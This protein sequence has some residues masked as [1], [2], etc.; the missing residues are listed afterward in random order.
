MSSD[1][2]KL[3]VKDAGSSSNPSAPASSFSMFP[4][5]PKKEVDGNKRARV[6]VEKKSS[7]PP[8][9]AQTEKLMRNAF[10]PAGSSS[11]RQRSPSPVMGGAKRGPK[12]AEEK[13]R[14][15]GEFVHK[16][17]QFCAYWE[18]PLLSE[19]L[20]EGGCIRPPDSAL[21]SV[22]ALDG[23]LENIRTVLSRHGAPKK[24]R[25]VVFSMMDN[26]HLL[27]NPLSK[28]LKKPVDLTGLGQAA[29]ECYG[30]S[31]RNPELEGLDIEAEIEE[32]AIEFDWLFSSRWW[33]RLALKTVTL[34]GAVAMN[35]DAM[36]SMG[37]D[38]SGADDF[39][40]PPGRV[41]PQPPP[42]PSRDEGHL[43]H[44][45]VPRD[46][47]HDEQNVRPRV[48]Q[49]SDSPPAI[50]R[51]FAS[52]ATAAAAAPTATTSAATTATTTTTAATTASAPPISG[53]LLGHPRATA[54]AA[55]LGQGKANQPPHTPSSESP[56]VKAEPKGGAG[57]CAEH[58][59]TERAIEK[60]EATDPA[61]S[62]EWNL[63]FAEAG[64]SGLEEVVRPKKKGSASGRG[65]TRK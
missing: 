23:E 3:G 27:N 30:K 20:L 28:A 15:Y 4:V 11:S 26:A 12:P 63:S 53:S 22:E 1:L 40:A 59:L 25:W 36:A 60:L 18:N 52:A 14:V 50:R 39:G 64:L 31:R 58:P 43:P 41:Y 42:L 33:S 16:F 6:D 34:G 48:V 7:Q 55:D 47:F 54:P 62:E 45:D 10:P 5:D 32:F 65:R 38:V 9:L 35:N 44:P 8:T 24:A 2:A 19:R 61:P 21:T 56:S 29:R 57:S 13:K 17:R 51:P 49:F 37:V 46:L